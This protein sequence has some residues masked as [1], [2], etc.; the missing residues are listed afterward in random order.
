LLYS[1]QFFVNILIIF[2]ISFF[3]SECF[4]SVCCFPSSCC[5]CFRPATY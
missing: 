3:L 5:R 4:Q 1:L 2:F